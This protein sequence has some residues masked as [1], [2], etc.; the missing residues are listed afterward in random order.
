M[1]VITCIA[2]AT[3]ERMGIAMNQLSGLVRHDDD[4]FLMIENYQDDGS[5]V[6]VPGNRVPFVFRRG[7]ATPRRPYTMI[8]KDKFDFV[9]EYATDDSVVCLYD[10]D[11]AYNPYALEAARVLFEENPEVNYASFL[12]GAG[13]QGE[14]ETL[15]GWKFIRWSSCMGGSTIVRWS[16]FKQHAA[17][18]FESCGLVGY[19]DAPVRIKGVFGQ[20]YWVFLQQKYGLTR[21]VYTLAWPFSLVQHCQFGSMYGHDKDGHTYAVDYDPLANIFDRRVK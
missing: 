19:F 21:Q 11:Y 1:N 8:I 5:H 18:F 10:D 12:R 2:S 17:A 13:L 9:S 20:S 15:S 3:K 16:V 14:D 6:V 4:K 7:D